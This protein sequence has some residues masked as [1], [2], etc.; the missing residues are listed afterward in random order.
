MDISTI[1]QV[2]V[3]AAPSLSAIITI[4]AGKIADSIREKRIVNK[5]LKESK[6]IVEGID[7]R[8]KK[9]VKDIAIMKTKI[10][11]IENYLL[12]EKEKK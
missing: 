1:E 5:A 8:N 12:E 7:E 9:Q 3:L 6:A 10:S 4:I 11:S 2:L